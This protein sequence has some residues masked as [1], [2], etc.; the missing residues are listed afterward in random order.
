MKKQTVRFYTDT[1]ETGALL[2]K[3]WV[4]LNKTT[5]HNEIL[6]WLRSGNTIMVDKHAVT[7]ANRDLFYLNR[8]Y[9]DCI[10][11]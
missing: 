3:G 9:A 8:Y 10:K 6:G 7:W 5:W 2:Y 4:Y 1:K 11:K